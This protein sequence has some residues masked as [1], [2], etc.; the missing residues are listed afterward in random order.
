M[1]SITIDVPY[2]RIAHDFS[3]LTE[4]LRGIGIATDTLSSKAALQRGITGNLRGGLWGA[5]FSGMSGPEDMT[6]L[7]AEATLKSM[8]ISNVGYGQLYG[9]FMEYQKMVPGY[10]SVP[11]F[12]IDAYA[13]IVS[14]HTIYS[15]RDLIGIYG[16]L[17]TGVP[18]LDFKLTKTGVQITV[19]ELKVFDEVKCF[20][21]DA[22]VLLA[23]GTKIEI[24]DIVC[25]DVVASFRGID[26]P[27]QPRPVTRLFRNITTEWIHITLSSSNDK[28]LLCTPGHH[29]QDEFGNFRTIADML[30]GGNG[31][32]RV[33]LAD[34]TVAEARGRSIMYSAETSHLY[35]QAEEVYYASGG[36]VALEPM[37]VKGWRTYNFEVEDLHTYVAGGIRVH[38]LSEIAAE[39]DDAFYDPLGIV[40]N[41]LGENVKQAM[42]NVDEAIQGLPAGIAHGAAAALLGGA[43]SLMSGV[44]NAGAHIALGVAGFAAN[45]AQGNVLGAIGSLAWGAVGAVSSVVGGVVGAVGAIAEGA[46]EMFGGIGNAIGGVASSIGNAIGGI[47]SSIG[48]AIG[49]IASSI[50]DAIGGIFGGGDDGT[51]NSDSDSKPV[52]LDLDG[53]GLTVDELSTSDQFV[54]FDGDGYLHRTAWAGTGDGVLVLDADGDGKISRSSEFA[55]AEWDPTADGDLAALKSVFDTNH[56]GLLDAGDER[57]SEFKVMRDGQIVTLASLGIASIGLT[58]T[59]SGQRFADGSAITGTSIFTRTDGTQ[60]EVGDAVLATEGE[61]YRISKY[62]TINAD[63]S[64]TVTS[65]GYN[66]DGSRAF[67]NRIT[68]S[69]DGKTIETEYDDDGN[70]VYDRSQTD[71]VTALAGGDRQRAISNFNTDGSLRDKTTTV[72]SADTRTVTTTVDQDGD[73]LA[74]QSQ[75]FVRNANGSTVTTVTANSVDGTILTKTVTSVSP[76]G[77]TKIIQSDTAGSNAFEFVSTETTTIAGDGSRTKTV[78]QKS[79]STTIANE[80]TTTSADGRNKTVLHDRDGNGVFEER[81]V[82]AMTGGA[83][84]VVVTKV[85]SFNADNSR[86]SEVT[87]TTS[88]DGLVKTT[89]TDADGDGAVDFVSSDVTLVGETGSLVQTIQTKSRDGTLLGTSTINTSADRNT[90]QISADTNGDGATDSVEAIVVD[91]DGLTT[92]TLSLLNPDGSLRSK[93]REQS[94]ANGLSLTTSSDLNGDGIYDVVV[95]DTTTHWSGNRTR[96]ITT[97]NANG[98]VVGSIATTT[99]AD[100]LSETVRE[101]LDGDAI[102][103]RTTATTTILNA[104]GSRTRTST[105][106]SADDTV[107]AKTVETTSADRKTVTTTI[108]ANGD[109][110]TDRQIVSVVNTNGNRVVTVKENIGGTLENKSETSFLADGL[111]VTERLDVNNDGV[112]DRRTDDTTV[113]A[114]TGIRT[115]TVAEYANGGSLLTNLLSKTTTTVSANGLTIDR[116]I[117]SDGDTVVEAKTSDVTSFGANGSTIRTVSSLTGAGGLVGKTITETSASGLI[118]TLKTDLDGNNSIDRTVTATIILGANGSRSET[119]TTK[120]GDD[121]VI[122]LSQTTI[123]ADKRNISATLDI[124]G[125]GT[126]DE[127]RT[128]ILN[129]DGSTTETSYTYGTSGSVSSKAIRTVSANGLT[130]TLSVDVNGNN[131]IDRSTTAVT[132][133]NADGSKTETISDFDAS[134]TLK[135]RTTIETSANGLSK[136]VKWAAIGATTSRSMSDTTALNADGSTTQTVAYR[137]ANGSLESQTITVVDADKKTSTVTRDVNGDGTVDLTITSVENPYGSVTTTS[138]GRYPGSTLTSSKTNT[139]SADGLSIV[140]QYGTTS[141]AFMPTATMKTTSDTILAA[142]GAKVETIK[143]YQSPASAPVLSSQARITRSADGF[144][145]TKEWDIGGDGTYDRKQ[146]DVTVLNANGLVAH[147]VSNYDGADPKSRYVTT[148]S[149]NGLSVTTNWH[150]FGSDAF[151]QETTDV[152]AVNASG[153]TTRTVTS[154]SDGSQL[155][156]FITTTSADGRVV[157]VQ[158]DID[159][160]VGFDRSKSLTLATLA[161]GTS[162]ETIKT[163]TIGGALLDSATVTTSGDK[164]T[165]SIVRDADG[166]GRTDQTEVRTDAVDGSAMTIITD[167]RTSGHK[168]SETKIVTSADGLTMTS[169]WD[170]DAN[171]TVDQRRV[172]TLVTNADGS[173]VTTSRDVVGTSGDQISKSITT[174]SDDGRSTYTATELNG[175]NDPD[176]TESVMVGVDGTVTIGTNNDADAR[177]ISR[178]LP[179]H[180]Y[181]R[182]QIAECLITIIS[183][184]GLT[185]TVMSDYGGNGYMPVNIVNPDTTNFEQTAISRT[186]ID[187]SVVTTIAEPWGDDECARGIV[188]VSADGRTTILKKDH[189]D[190]GTYEHTETAVT[191][192]DGTIRHTAVDLNSNGTVQQTVTTEVSADGRSTFVLTATGSSGSGTSAGIGV[193][194]SSSAITND[195]INGSTGDDDLDGGAG[196]DK[197]YGGT[198]HD[199]LD[200]GAGADTLHGDGGND[201]YYVDNAGDQIAED[202]GEGTDTVRSTIDFAIFDI[203]VENLILDGT[204]NIKATGNDAANRLTGNSGANVLNGEGDDDQLYGGL[205][206]D[207]LFGGAGNDLVDAG[208]GSGAWQYVYG[209]GGDDT[210]RIGK[211][212]G[213]VFID[214]TSEAEAQGTDKVVFADLKVSDLTFSHYDYG[215]SNDNG[216]SLQINWTGGQLRIGQ[217]AIHIEG[218]EFADG[219]TVKAVTTDELGRLRFWGTTGSD[220][221]CG[222]NDADTLYGGEGNDVLDAG[223]GPGAWQYLNG[224]DGDDTYKIGKNNGSVF[225]DVT[226]ESATQGTDRVIF[227]DLKISDLSFSSYDYGTSNVNGLSV[228]MAWSDGKLRIGQSGDYIERFE[229]ADGTVLSNIA[230]SSAPGVSVAGT[231]GND[232]L[233]GASG[234]E[235]FYGGLGDDVL[236][237]GA[238]TGAAWQYLFGDDGNDTYRIGKNSG[239]V[240]IT[241]AGESATQGTDKVV[242]TDL[243]VSD[244][245]FGHVDYGTS[246]PNGLSL[247]INW[248]GGQFRV[249]QAG[250]YIEG[251]EFADGTTVKEITIDWLGRL[252]LLGTSADDIICGS[253]GVDRLYGGL[254]DDVLDAGAGTGAAWQYLFGEDGND[255]YRIGQNNG[256]VV[257]TVAGES[258][259]QGTDKVVFTDLRVSDLSFGHV[260]YGTSDPNGLSLQINWTGGQFLI[261]QAGSYIE[262]FEFSDGTKVSKIEIDASN[263]LLLWGTSGDETIRGGAGVDVLYGLAG[264]DVL[265]GGRGNDSLSGGLGHDRYYFNAGDGADTIWESTY[266]DN[267]QLTFGSG[268]DWD[269]LW[270]SKQDNNLVVSVLGTTDKVTINNWF[271]SIGNVV[272]TIRSG[273]GNVLHHSDVASLV[274]AMASFEPSTSATSEGIRPDDPRLGN[275]SQAGTILAAMTSAWTPA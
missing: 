157:T 160:V 61:G 72:T 50:G 167:W 221:I 54:D 131:V 159:G 173:R 183:A 230:I 156:K 35:E 192:I 97:K 56:N 13:N 107:L 226:R 185:K 29:F 178:L 235:R 2:D 164:R 212:N 85:S 236:D 247:Q 68:T 53:N 243:K 153:S 146:T 259:T 216:L 209:E 197:I 179:G 99:T 136:T 73:G 96:T 11:G 138:S 38:N 8:G 41:L 218:F 40:S 180:V 253:A 199:I 140:T 63:G 256:L 200:G 205:G 232:L 161:D 158:E 92:T 88:A 188:T 21:G 24:K 252:R 261:G 231:D 150:R 98:D 9:D 87:T 101:E 184:D 100:G 32:A 202:S 267:D 45:L 123:S 106:T 133:L 66:K 60:G 69:A 126:V 152:T 240:I 75:V 215:T 89:S 201:T 110:K 91:A 191:R 272:E 198:G 47:A 112:Y 49:G 237:A 25:G 229:F 248:T 137:K 233:V 15:P 149:A 227:T 163:L 4:A 46:G 166:D 239:A 55:F 271:L 244:L 250:N 14:K 170:F 64:K 83:N 37:V 103:D 125:N 6:V 5:I 186:Q 245:S 104:G 3:A 257:I 115:R 242:F 263:R 117:D 223:V 84:D 94:A 90:R 144:S 82:S 220:I 255:T 147:T 43:T 262:G 176:I 130:E 165:V 7:A 10:N 249:G 246:D 238:G 190:N 181:W 44:I 102:V 260:D 155:S 51:S 17:K 16:L 222:S 22:K 124:D 203:S 265:H 234:D 93:I 172:T 254:G 79:G 108:D 134:G 119:V 168:S 162:V 23:D 273:D 275:P 204:A 187:G 154:K 129:E 113:I 48:D 219:T 36:A 65:S 12:Y 217:T 58:P 177:N 26:G 251:F 266:G 169:D 206:D 142:D 19:D 42:H 128:T 268:I 127:R 95:A 151:S 241:V 18:V 39:V 182:K 225:M 139:V 145:T 171:G 120:N 228:Q 80:T 214:A 193:E 62:G 175:T 207:R 211:N 174:T 1:T 59:G 213:S 33:V 116:L 71:V 74:D 143:N 109:T 52:L 121:D 114:A 195:T 70:G 148:T 264:D 118:S 135:N 111:T 27:M 189:D 57:W 270:F 67:V 269:E 31:V 258:A 196:L 76:D 86:R 210:Y 224:E 20:S 28:P 132:A 194:F 208:A 122:S 141:N 30:A 78:V 274:A 34:G 105:T 81:V 77:L